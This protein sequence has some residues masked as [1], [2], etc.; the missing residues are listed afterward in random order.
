MRLP[1]LGGLRLEGGSFSRSKPL[2]PLAYLAL[3]GAK[4]RRFLAELF[5][6][7]AANPRRSLNTALHQLRN[8]GIESAFLCRCPR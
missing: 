6:L 5:W 7:G 3:E 4:E 8:R 2:L 1:T